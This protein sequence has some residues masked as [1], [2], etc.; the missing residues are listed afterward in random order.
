MFTIICRV[1]RYLC[2]ALQ[3]KVKSRWRGDELVKTRVVSGFIFLRLLC[4]AILNPRQ[5]NLITEAPSPMAHRTLKLTANCLIKLANLVEAKEPY[6]EV[7]NPFIRDNQ[8][9]MVMFLDELSN[10]PD[11]PQM[12][13]CPATDLARSLATIH[14]ICVAHLDEI[15]KLSQTKPYIKKLGTV[16]EMLTNH[17]KHYMSNA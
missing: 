16:T 17:K 8:Q 5:F 11:V 6:M 1:L 9:R 3:K 15:Q 12:P 2:W 7:I 14:Q 4:L 10:C 13:E